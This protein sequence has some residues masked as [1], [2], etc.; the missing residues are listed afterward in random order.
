MN[1]LNDIKNE[2]YR[3][4]ERLGADSDLLSIVGSWR[5]TLSE[6]E[7]LAELKRYNNGEPAFKKIIAESDDVV[8]FD[9]EQKAKHN[10]APA[11]V[12]PVVDATDICDC[13]NAVYCSGH[14]INK[15]AG[16]EACKK[17]DPLNPYKYFHGSALAPAPVDAPAPVEPEPCPKCYWKLTAADEEDLMALCHPCKYS[18]VHV[19]NFKE[20]KNE[21]T[22]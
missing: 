2:I 15:M 6:E 4:L 18:A 5:D 7:I 9:A 11:P 20:V 21:Q 10:S 19:D 3:T 17:G 22:K 13:C 8:L 14:V 16:M 1:L 12:A